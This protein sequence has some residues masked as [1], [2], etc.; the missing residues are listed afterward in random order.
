MA[1]TQDQ[2][3]TESWLKAQE[4]LNWAAIH[5][6]MTKTSDARLSDY[7]WDDART[8]VF[9]GLESWLGADLLNFEILEVE[10]S[11]TT[12]LVRGVLDLVFRV[13]PKPLA[14]Q[15]AAWAGRIFI[16]DWKTSKNTLGG[17]W[18]AR[19]IA[20]WQA[21]IYGVLAEHVNG[22]SEMPAAFEFRGISR[23]RE[24]KPVLLEY[25]SEASD[26]TYEFLWQIDRMKSSLRGGT[27]KKWP[28]NRPFACNAYGRPCVYSND[29]DLGKEHL[30]Q[31]EAKPLSYS[32]VSTFMLCPEKFRRQ[33]EDGSRDS[34][35]TIFGSVVHA[36]LAEAYRQAQN[37]NI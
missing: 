36:G 7:D 16:S 28:Q 18:R 13:R 17:E 2:R 22:F 19:H 29:C 31:I 1:Q 26:L 3:A 27:T 15:Y 6:E 33:Q 37:W 9:D 25:G 32:G 21:P 20:S 5:E 12:P 8:A 34:D 24:T 30:V 23:A 11:V 4:S 14:G 10:K 35:E